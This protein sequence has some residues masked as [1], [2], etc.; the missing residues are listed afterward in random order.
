MVQ[1]TLS[2]VLGLDHLIVGKPVLGTIERLEESLYDM[3]VVCPNGS[4]RPRGCPF[5]ANGMGSPA[6]IYMIPTGTGLVTLP[7]GATIEL[8]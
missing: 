5:A 4:L 1:R 7:P 6:A 2:K 3:L 8:H